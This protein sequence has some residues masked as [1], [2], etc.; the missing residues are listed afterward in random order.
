MKDDSEMMNNPG[1]DTPN[2]NSGP[3]PNFFIVGT[4]K[5]GSTSISNFFEQHPDVC[6]CRNFEPNF[7][8]F[9]RLYSRG[10]ES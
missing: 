5:T 8:A 1:P 9:D 3:L 6:F 10:M 4:A 7:F 2:S